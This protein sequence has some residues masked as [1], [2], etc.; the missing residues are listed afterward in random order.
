[1]MS[2]IK[3][4]ICMMNIV[5]RAALLLSLVAAC[6]LGAETPYAPYRPSFGG[7]YYLQYEACG[8]DTPYPLEEAL[9]CE[10][11][12]CVWDWSAPRDSFICEETWCCH[13]EKCE[14]FLHYQECYE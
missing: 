9:V 13:A 2:I 5:I 6:E 8:N 1:M 4:G 7:D 11:A 12:C 14:W 10:E 3:S